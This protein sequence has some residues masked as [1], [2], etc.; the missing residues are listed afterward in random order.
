MKLQEIKSALELIK[1]YNKI[2]IFRHFRPDGDA[3]GSTLGL[4]RILRLSYPDKD[5]RVL[6]D[7]Y[8]DYLSFLGEEDSAED[9][10]YEGALGIVVDTATSSRI[11]NKKYTLCDKIVKIDHHI[12]VESYGDVNWEDDTKA[13]ASEMIVELYDACRDELKIDKAAATAIYLGIVTDSGRFRFS[14]V[15]G[16]TLR[17][18]AILLDQGIDTDTLFAR[19]Y[20]KEF[21]LYKFESYVYKKMKRTESGVAYLHVDKKMQEQFN[22]SSEDASASVSYLDSIKDSLIW[23]VFIDNDDGTIRVR[24]RSRFVTINKLAEKYNGGGHACASGATVHSKKEIKQ[25]LGDADELL[26]VYKAE[27]EGWL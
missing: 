15:G 18:A 21:E 17:Y 5:I 24:L 12:P 13:S 8:A 16:D 3:V 11:S 4:A 19:L 26:R 10:F 27:N 9:S 2:A 14:S 1:S 7:D 23:M 6:N 20:M 25:L 22:L